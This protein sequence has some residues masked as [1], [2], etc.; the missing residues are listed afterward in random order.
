[1]PRVIVVFPAPNFP[2][3]KTKSPRCKVSASLEPN[4]SMASGVSMMSFMV[5][6]NPVCTSTASR[7]HFVVHG[8]SAF[9]QLLGSGFIAFRVAKNNYLITD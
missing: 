5:L 9:R 8:S 2:E 7:N 4:A 3:S 6:E 1:M